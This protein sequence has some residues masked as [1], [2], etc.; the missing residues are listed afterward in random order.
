ML[1]RQMKGWAGLLCSVAWLAR[2]VAGDPA[3][4]VVQWGA[5]VMGVPADATNVATA[6][7]E[8]GCAAAIRGDGS[9]MVWGAFLG[10]NAPSRLTNALA[11]AAGPR[12]GVTISNGVPVLWGASQG[13]QIYPVPPDLTN[14]VAVACANA[15]IVL[16]AD[17]TVAWWYP[18]ETVLTNAVAIAGGQNSGIALRPDG[19]VAT[20]GIDPCDHGMLDIPPGLGSVV[21]IASGACFNA[22]L[23]ADGHVVA[24]GDNTYGQ[25]NVPANLTNAM[26]IAAGSLHCVA[27]RSDGTVVAWGDNTFNQ[28]RVPAGLS[29]VLS[30]AAGGNSSLAITGMAR[31][32]VDVVVTNVVFGPDGFKARVPTDRGN[33]YALEYKNSLAGTEW[34]LLPLVAGTGSDVDLVDTNAPAQ[35]RFY[36][37]RRW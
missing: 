36:R 30:I 18:Y 9:L 6:S 15:P 12:F 4:N 7:I 5:I 34:N 33:V 16:R 10:T 35:Q 1:V 32:R 2:A 14:V 28:T 13:G 37:V 24:W 25:T 29:N 27:L 31:P 8:E 17:S 11:V 26:A 22:A 19:T 21:S 3:P 23:R 20:W